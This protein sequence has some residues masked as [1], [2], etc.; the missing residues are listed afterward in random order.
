M[1][2]PKETKFYFISYDTNVKEIPLNDTVHGSKIEED[3]QF[4][5]WF[6]AQMYA[7]IRCVFYRYGLPVPKCAYIDRCYRD[8]NKMIITLLRENVDSEKEALKWY[9]NWIFVS[10]ELNISAR[11]NSDYDEFTFKF[12]II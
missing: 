5:N 8:S 4:D 10:D 12:K 9:K 2:S 3:Q 6:F 7:S 1:E 11:A